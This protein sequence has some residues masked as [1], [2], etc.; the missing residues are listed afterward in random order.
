MNLKEMMAKEKAYPLSDVSKLEIPTTN[1]SECDDHL[2]FLK[3]L[4]KDDIDIAIIGL[5]H[6][7]DELLN[8]P[9]R[10]IV[11][12]TSINFKNDYETKKHDL[13]CLRDW[14]VCWESIDY[15]ELKK[16]RLFCISLTLS[17]FSNFY[18]AGK[19]VETERILNESKYKIHLMNIT[20]DFW[21]NI[22]HRG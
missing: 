21:Y 3:D 20:N 12:D 4:T 7:R 10:G 22:A 16:Q 13:I 11:D 14:W 17:D 18:N 6:I 19:I 15:N 5:D 1:K 8:N 9:K 2:F